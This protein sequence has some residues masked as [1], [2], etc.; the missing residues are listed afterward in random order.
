[1]VESCL[2]NSAIKTQTST[3]NFVFFYFNVYVLH[4]G[5]NVHSRL[6]LHS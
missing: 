5:I 2:K 4:T 3:Y 1:M 6:N